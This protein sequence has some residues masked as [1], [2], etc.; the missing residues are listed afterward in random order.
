[1]TPKIHHLEHYSLLIREFGPLINYSTLRF[2]RAHQI[3]KNSIAISRCSQNIPFQIAIAY[4]KSMANKLEKRVHDEMTITPEFIEHLFP[5]EFVRFVNQ[6]EQ[7]TLLGS[8][9]DEDSK[10]QA[11]HLYLAESTYHSQFRYPVF[12]C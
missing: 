9:L 10:I 4:S 3:G 7:Q 2:E 12:F 11:G 1:M 8:T 6:D 5:A